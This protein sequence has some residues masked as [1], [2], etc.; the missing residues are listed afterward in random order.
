MDSTLNYPHR[1]LDT[2]LLMHVALV[3]VTDPGFM[4]P[5]QVDG[6]AGKKSGSAGVFALENALTDNG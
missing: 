6:G 1:T 3:H 4:F 2:K 5:S